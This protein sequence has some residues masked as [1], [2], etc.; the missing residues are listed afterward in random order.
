EDFRRHVYNEQYALIDPEYAE[1]RPA[2]NAKVVAQIARARPQMSILDY[3]G[4][5]GRL[6]EH[7]RS[8]GFTDVTTY[9]PFIPEFCARPTRR[10]ELVSSFE[11][12]E[13]TPD[14]ARTLAEI[15][16]LV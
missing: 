13:H 7:L 15:A 1:T 2:I 9:D 14:P 4:G 10:F 12:L 16:G 11:V 3:G 8:A 6:A 5:N